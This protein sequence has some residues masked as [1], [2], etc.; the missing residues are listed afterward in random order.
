MRECQYDECGADLTGYPPASKYCSLA[1]AA[2]AKRDQHTAN[3]LGEL[4]AWAAQMGLDVVA[5]YVTED[6]AWASGNGNGKGAEFEDK[7]TAMLQGVRRGE[8]P[9]VL[10]W[11]IDRL[12]R[13][14]TE[15]MMRY[16]RLLA[17]A[18]ADV[19][20][21]H[22]P[23][24][25]TADPMARELLVGVFATLAKY[26]S[27]RRSERIRAGLARRK[28]EGKP[29]GRQPGATDKGQRRRSGYVASWE[30]DGAR[31]AAQ[32]SGGEGS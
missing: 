13:R 4:E 32:I 5:T 22:D 31:R 30:T 11:A 2:L 14:G 19:R 28:A 20:S 24:L 6:S 12:S 23:W 16:L 7:R 8:H 1:H 27:Q 21:R 10:C 26:E 3:Q 18:G 25:Q 15:D 9:V 17:E 29:V